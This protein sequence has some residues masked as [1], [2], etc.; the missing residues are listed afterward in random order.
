LPVARLA[1]P[2]TV[3]AGVDLSLARAVAIDAALQA[4]ALLR[5]RRAT[6]LEVRHKGRVDI[7]TDVDLASEALVRSILGATFP[8]HG[9]LGEEGGIDRGGAD[10]R[11]RWIVDPLDGTTNYAHGFA[12][13]CVSIALEVDG[14]VQVGVIYDPTADE[15][16]VAVRGQGAELNGRPIGV[17]Q[18]SEL[19]E[20]LLATGFPYDHT[21]LPMAV[22]AFGDVSAAC[23]AVRR[24]GSAALDLA[25]VACGRFDGYWEFVLKAWDMAAGVLIVQEAGGAATLVDGAP[26]RLD[27]EQVLVTNGHLQQS[28]VD[29]VD[30]SRQAP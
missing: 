20:A 13:Y 23:Q 12:F 25:Y 6:V 5:Q 8:D 18:V 3:A 27:A 1:I 17:S 10:A 16:F 21:L 26:F 30:R 19:S 28:L 7:V 22:K 29:A 24:A 14:T 4:G 2:V 15:L 11:M 9:V